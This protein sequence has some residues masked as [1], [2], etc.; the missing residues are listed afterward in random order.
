[1]VKICTH[2]RKWKM[3]PVELFQELGSKNKGEW[4]RK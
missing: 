1:M 2:V 4:W 3:R